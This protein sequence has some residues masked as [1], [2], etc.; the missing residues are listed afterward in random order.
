MRAAIVETM[1]GTPSIGSVE[2]DEPGIGEV[3][4]RVVA[5]GVC[6]SDVHA[7]SGHGI[8]FPVPFVPGHEPA[9][10]VEAVGPGVR[11]LR[12][13]DHVVAC[14]SV[15]C[16]HCANCVTGRSYRCFTDDFARPPDDPPRLRRG[17]ETVH[18]FVGLGSFAE[19]MLVSQN[20]VVKI[21]RTL[22]LERACLLGCGVLTGVGAALN[23]AQV[24]PGATVAVVGCGGVGLSVIQGARLAYASQVIAVD[25]DDAKLD[26]ARRCGATD[27]VNA[28]VDDPVPA[29]QSL[30]RGGVDFAFEAIGLPATVQQA[31]AMAG[32]GGTLT[33]VGIADVAAGFTFT[34]ADLMMG[35]R[36]Q[37]SLMGSNRFAADIPLLVDHVLAGRLDLDAMVS[38]E[39]P[40]DHLAD[41][42]AALDA[43]QILGR[44]VITF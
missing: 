33:V 27:V 19:Q 7:L 41:T 39:R 4:L 5:S 6:H 13:G 36:I 35:K 15:Y 40:L 44:A 14:L 9:G 29:V 22:P 28:A 24:T 10:V 23:T 32:P 2:I 38:T 3:L 30:T 34:G 37:Q 43:G 16:G 12:P 31:L 8:A 17:D 26:L 42:L 11:H 20:N 1:P 18:Q 25:V 21:D